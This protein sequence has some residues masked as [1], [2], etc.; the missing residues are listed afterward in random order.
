[1]LNQR[2]LLHMETPSVSYINNKQVNQDHSISLRSNNSFENSQ[3]QTHNAYSY[4]DNDAMAIQKQHFSNL[5]SSNTP[6]KRSGIL[7]M[8]GKNVDLDNSVSS[9]YD[10]SGVNSTINLSYLEDNDHKD[11]IYSDDIKKHVRIIDAKAGERYILIL[12]ISLG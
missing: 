12:I 4:T 5:K 7:K 2:L 10:H 8:K 1:M 6:Y 3:M 11:N 9:A